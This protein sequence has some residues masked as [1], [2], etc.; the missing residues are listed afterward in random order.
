MRLATSLVAALLASTSIATRIADACGGDYGPRAPAMFLVSNHNGRTFV[1][2]DKNVATPERLAWSRERITY[3]WTEV[4]PGTAFATARKLTL[5][6][7]DRTRRLASANHVFVKQASDSRDPMNALEIFP[8]GVEQARIA[9]DGQFTSVVWNELASQPLGLETVAWAQ[10]PGFS[11]PIDPQMMS[12]SKV[13]G[14]DLELITGWSFD[15]HGKGI[16]A[17]YVRTPGAKPYG[18]YRGAP[19]GVVTLD[20]TR[21][22]VLV[23]DGLVTPVAI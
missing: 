12:L 19:I 9:V 14:T 13:V 17:T 10:N 22:L 2:L 1:L 20:G 18:G 21:Y 7:A 6:G 8:K 3:D 23:D 5:V 15:I 4:A 11:P 16:S